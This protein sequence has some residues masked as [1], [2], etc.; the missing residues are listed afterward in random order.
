MNISGD[1][2][3]INNFIKYLSIVSKSITE[4]IKDDNKAKIT[5]QEYNNIK[6][7][8]K[9]ITEYF[10]NNDNNDNNSDMNS[11][12]DDDID[13]DFLEDK[14]ETSNTTQISDKFI[15]KI[16]NN[17]LSKDNLIAHNLELDKKY[18]I[19]TLNCLNK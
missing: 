5:I 19:F 15:L 17:E 16:K 2:E 7:L 6:N 4:K 10:N 1:L 12:V 9:I 13:L 3:N 8:S 18:I 11:I 14:Q